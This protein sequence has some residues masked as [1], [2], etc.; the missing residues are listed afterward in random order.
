MDKYV[1]GFLF[2]EKHDWVLLIEKKRP[3]WQIGLLNGVGGHIED[4]E[5]SYSAMVREFEEEAGVLNTNWS[6]FAILRKDGEWQVDFYFSDNPVWD[7]IKQKTD[8]K[9]VPVEVAKLPDNTIYNLRWLIPLALD[10]DVVRPVII[11]AS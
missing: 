1:V 10:K 11:E 7:S 9:L 6:Q 8:E 3:K 2:N 5:P 4:G